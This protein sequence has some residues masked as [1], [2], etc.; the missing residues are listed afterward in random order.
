MQQ[1]TVMNI[2]LIKMLVLLLIGAQVTSP[3]RSFMVVMLQVQARAKL[4]FGQHIRVPVHKTVTLMF[5]SISE[6]F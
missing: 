6:Y 3:W 1:L 2:L 4:K 5:N